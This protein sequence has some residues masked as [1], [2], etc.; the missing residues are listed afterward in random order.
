[1]AEFDA[2]INMSLGKWPKYKKFLNI[3]ESYLRERT[4][5]Y[6][7]TIIINIIFNIS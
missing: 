4:V 5:Q 1:M 3:Y 6:Y 7:F 2:K